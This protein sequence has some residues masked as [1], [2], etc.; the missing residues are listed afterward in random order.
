MFLTKKY[1]LT[2]IL[3]ISISLN[4]SSQGAYDDDSRLFRFG[5]SLGFNAFDFGV[6]N[7]LQ[8][9]D[10]EVYSADVSNLKPGFS[11][12][13]VSD[14]LLHR[15]LNLRFTPT[16]HFGERELTYSNESGDKKYA[17]V[18][19]SVPLSLP[20]YLKYSSE[21]YGDL[22]PYL[23]GGGGVYFDLGQN[24]EKPVY[25][26]TFDSFVEFGVGCDIYFSFFKLA[27]EL[28]FA[29][30]FNDVFY[31]NPNPNL[32]DEDKLKN[33]ALS[34]LTSRVLTLTFNFE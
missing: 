4:V 15:Y 26:R 25:L 13:V 11:V 1:L 9:I 7:S 3:I 6:T 30:G 8:N 20:V 5:F 17:V 10:G 34:K 19:P 23:I 32:L 14:M 28:K 16:L 21:R 18:I 29:I 12:G 33:M 31:P 22:R 24:K 27:P 2:L